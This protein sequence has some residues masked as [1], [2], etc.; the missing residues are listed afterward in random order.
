MIAKFLKTHRYFTIDWTH[1]AKIWK[2]LKKED[3][4]GKKREKIS[5]FQ[6]QPRILT[7]G[8]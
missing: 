2:G 6:H 4:F 7:A 3:D 1:I 5:F 8:I